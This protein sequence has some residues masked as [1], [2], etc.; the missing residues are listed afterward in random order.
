MSVASLVDHVASAKL[1]EVSLVFFVIRQPLLIP[2]DMSRKNFEY[3]RI[4]E[5]L[6]VFVIDSLVYSPPGSRDSPL[7]SPTRSRDYPVNSSLGIQD[8]LL[9]LHRGVDLN[10]FTKEPAGEKYT[11]ESRLPYA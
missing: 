3:F 5:E 10:G 11:R 4:F 9:I 1:Y 2:L 7:Y 6:F 8:S